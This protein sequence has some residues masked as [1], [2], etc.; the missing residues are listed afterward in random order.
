MENYFKKNKCDIVRIEV[1]VSN[2]KAHGFYQKM[3]YNNRIIDMI[4]LI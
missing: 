4:K 3:N 1:F 2:K